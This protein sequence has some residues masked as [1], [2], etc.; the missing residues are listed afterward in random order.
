MTYKAMFKCRLCGE[1]FTSGAVTG[2]KGLAVQAIVD[3]D[4][5]RH[6]VIQAPHSI[7]THFCENGDIGYAD[8]IGWKVGE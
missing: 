1:V 6:T 8:F 5:N 4:L 2:N 3:M 7:Q